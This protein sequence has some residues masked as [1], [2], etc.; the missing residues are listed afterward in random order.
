[1]DL[2]QALFKWKAK[3]TCLVAFDFDAVMQFH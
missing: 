1:M 2:D 3:S